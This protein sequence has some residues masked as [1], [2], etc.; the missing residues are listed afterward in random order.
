MPMRVGLGA[1]HAGCGLKDALA[2]HLVARGVQPVD[3]GTGDPSVSVDYPRFAEA[4][5][6]AVAAGQIDLGVLCCGTGIGMA[7]AANKVPGIR[8]A[9]VHD[10]TTARLAREH[11]NANIITMG[12]RLIA[13]AFAV[14]VL[15][16]F[17]DATFQSRH[18]RRLD[19]IS[20]IESGGR[21][22]PA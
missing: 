20:G 4:V 2:A 9:L 10:V 3:F 12:G 8:A 14:D 15:D 21:G 5:A 11:N 6:R 16:A 7:I 19:Q 18:Q 17:L 1:D 13:P 22:G